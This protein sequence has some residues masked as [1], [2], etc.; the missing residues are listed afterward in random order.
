MKKTW[1][2]AEVEELVID[3]TAHGGK[4]KANHDGLWQQN[5]DGTWWEAT[6]IVGSTK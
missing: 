6:H 5:S 1:E 3:E 2:N 4:D